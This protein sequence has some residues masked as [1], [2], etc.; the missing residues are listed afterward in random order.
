MMV[1]FSL[2]YFST[3]EK[4]GKVSVTILKSLSYEYREINST[5][6][7]IFAYKWHFFKLRVIIVILYIIT[8]HF[9]HIKSFK[10]IAIKLERISEKLCIKIKGKSRKELGKSFSLILY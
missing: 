10:K 9:I 3:K 7:S 4:W 5:M 6:H 8:Y 2:K 1:R